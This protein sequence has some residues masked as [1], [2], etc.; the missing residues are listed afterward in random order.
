LADAA[1]VLMALPRLAELRSDLEAAGL[2]D[3]LG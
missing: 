2:G 1:D 3:L